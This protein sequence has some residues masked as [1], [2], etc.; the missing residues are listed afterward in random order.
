MSF[1][2]AEQ[3]KAWRVQ[4]GDSESPPAG[5][6]KSSEAGLGEV[7]SNGRYVISSTMLAVHL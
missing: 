1:Q 2:T 7:A 4:G 3:E 6:S 5:P